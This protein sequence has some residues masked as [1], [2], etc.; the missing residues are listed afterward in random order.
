MASLVDWVAS[1]S[2]ADLVGSSNSFSSLGPS[3]AATGASAWSVLQRAQ[4][5][6]GPRTIGGSHQ[7]IVGNCFSAFLL[8]DLSTLLW[9]SAAMFLLFRDWLVFLCVA[10]GG[11]LQKIHLESYETNPNA[12]IPHMI[13][14]NPRE[15]KNIPKYMISCLFLNCKILLT[16]W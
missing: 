11:K 13:L 10:R 6:G 3:L 4:L 16:E 15:F 7:G 14:R 5:Q 8:L 2:L 9:N 12:H 1:S